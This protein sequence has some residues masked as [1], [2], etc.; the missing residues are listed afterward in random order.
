MNYTRKSNIYQWMHK[1]PHPGLYRET[2]LPVS[3]TVSL[4]A[5]VTTSWINLWY[6][7]T[8]QC[9][10]PISCMSYWTIYFIVSFGKRISNCYRVF[11][12]SAIT[13]VTRATFSLSHLLYRHICSRCPAQVTPLITFLPLTS[14]IFL[15]GTCSNIN[16]AEINFSASLL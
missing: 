10:F 4:R 6:I 14:Q 5:V 3:F 8:H 11:G 16:C 9:L 7:F 15:T 13:E 1:L 12:L 2:I